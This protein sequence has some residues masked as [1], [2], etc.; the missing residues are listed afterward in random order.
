[1]KKKGHNEIDRTIELVETTIKRHEANN[2]FPLVV[3][4][5]SRPPFNHRLFIGFHCA[6]STV[7]FHLFR[8]RSHV[9]GIICSVD[10]G[11]MKN[12]PTSF[13]RNFVINFP[14]CSRQCW[15]LY[16]TM[17]LKCEVTG[18]FFVFVRYR[19]ED[20]SWRLNQKIQND[21]GIPRISLS[22][23]QQLWK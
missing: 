9:A 10:V 2:N 4:D 17:L 8:E 19:R 22:S 20:I 6:S 16:Q 11:A 23:R 5:I 21:F 12:A 13:R 18:F 7:I 15:R 1:M 3:H 14:S